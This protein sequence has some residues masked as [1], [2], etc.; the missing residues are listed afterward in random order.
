MF[1]KKLIMQYLCKNFKVI[2]NNNDNID[3]EI[4]IILMK[5]P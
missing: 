3:N 1:I 5:I 4:V 2:K